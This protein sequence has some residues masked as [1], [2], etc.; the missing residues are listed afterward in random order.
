MTLSADSA[1][2]PGS[3]LSSDEFRGCWPGA[4][5]PANI[6]QPFRLPGTCR[7][8]SNARLIDQGFARG[9]EDLLVGRKKDEPLLRDDF[10][11]DAYGEFAEAAFDQ[12]GL[13]SEFALKQSRHPDGPR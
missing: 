10:A 5:P 4:S 7:C 13:H 3:H 6:W 12:F 2:S 8:D 9:V 1:T 11:A